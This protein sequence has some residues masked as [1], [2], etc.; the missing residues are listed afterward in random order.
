MTQGLVQGGI[1]IP[2]GTYFLPLRDQLMGTNRGVVPTLSRDCLQL[3][4]SSRCPHDR[5]LSARVDCRG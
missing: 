5:R 1:L 3:L 2:E 4:P